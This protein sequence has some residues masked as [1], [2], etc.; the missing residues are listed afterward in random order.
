MLKMFSLAFP[1][2][3]HTNNKLNY[4]LLFLRYYIYKCRLENNS[5]PLQ[6]IIDIINIIKKQYKICL[7]L[8]SFNYKT[9]R[10]C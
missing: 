2:H 10:R 5:V 3:Q 6:L 9:I 7:F 4:T 8:L 1:V